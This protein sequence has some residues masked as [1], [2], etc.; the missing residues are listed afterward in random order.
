M[1]DLKGYMQHEV[2]TST[3]THRMVSRVSYNMLISISIGVPLPL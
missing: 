3:Y 2:V 1:G